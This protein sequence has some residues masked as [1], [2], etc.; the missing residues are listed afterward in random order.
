MPAHLKTRINMKWAD[1]VEYETLVQGK[2]SSSTICIITLQI[3]VVGERLR[4]AY[5]LFFVAYRGIL[6]F[7]LITLNLCDK[8]LKYGYNVTFL[9]VG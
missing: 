2:W 9:F 4:A 3:Y 7:Y 5:I 6:K 8:S 1:R